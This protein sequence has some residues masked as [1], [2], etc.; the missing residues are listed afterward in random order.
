[1]AAWK[2]QRGSELAM[3]AAV[4][5]AKHL[6]DGEGWDAVA[7]ALGLK[8]EAARF[9]GRSDDSVPV[10]VRMSAFEA[11]KPGT[12][13]IYQA[14]RMNDGD[15]G[16]FGLRAVREQPADGQQTDADLKRQFAQAI[17]S[18]DAQSYAKAARADA[19]VSVNPQAID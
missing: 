15:A 10:E 1:M 3:A 13:P 19:T 9:V 2:K 16:V 6:G 8:A 11:P 17:A 4:D 14:V 7:K 12:Q 18:A 5:A